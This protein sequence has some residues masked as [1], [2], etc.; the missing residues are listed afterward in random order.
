MCIYV[1]GLPS[2]QLDVAS[3]T[4]L[5]LPL[6]LDEFLGVRCDHADVSECRNEQGHER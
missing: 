2:L 6:D 1:V 5:V 3:P 4:L